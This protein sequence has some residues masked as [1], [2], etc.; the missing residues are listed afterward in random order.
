V[1]RVVYVIAIRGDARGGTPRGGK[2]RSPTSFGIYA[3]LYYFLFFP[4]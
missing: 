2:N 4:L 1:V 3:I